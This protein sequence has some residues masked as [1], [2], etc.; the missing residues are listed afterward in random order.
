L[1]RKRLKFLGFIL[2]NGKCYPDPNKVDC[3]NNYPKPKRPLHIN[4]FLGLLGFYRRFIPNMSAIAL[5]LRKLTKKDAVWDWTPECQS[6][7]ETLKS[8]LTKV[9]SVHLPDLNSPFIISC[10]G[11]KSGLGAVLSQ[12][13][14]G[15][16]YPIY[17]ASKKLDEIQSRYSAPEFELLAVIWAIEKFEGYI[18]YTNFILETDHE[19]IKWLQRMKEPSGRQGRWFF[20]LQGYQFEVRH[21][22]GDSL[23]M[24]VPDALSR[25]YEVN[26]V[27][28]DSSFCRNL[29]IKEQLTDPRMIEV[30]DFLLGTCQTTD[31]VKLESLR[32]GS[33]RTFIMEDGMLMR[34]V[35]PK[36]KPW[37]DEGLYW[38]IWLPHNL[39]QKVLSLFHESVLAGHLG[40]RKTFH[41][42][43]EKFYWFAMRRDVVNFVK[44]CTK[45]QAIK[46]KSIPIAPGTSYVAQGPW[47][48]VF[49]DIMGPYPRTARQNTHLLVVVDGFSKYVEIFALSSPN[50]VKVT[51]R[52]WEVC[53]RW[54][55]FKTLVSDN[56]TQFTAAH[57]FDWC[58]ALD[59]TPF[60]ISAYHAQ[61]NMTE[62]YNAT[63]K[64]VIISFINTHKDW[65]K[66]LHEVC[67]AL[68]SAVNDST[69]FTP[70]YLSTGRELR[71]P[72]DNLLGITI[73]N[74][75]IAEL[76]HR[77][78]MIYNLARDNLVNSQE[79][80]IRYYNR[81]TKLREFLVGAKVMYRTHFLSD[82][83]KGFCAK[84]APR[85]EGPYV[86]LEKI[87]NSVYDLKNCETGQL[88][89]KV[90][91]NDLAS[92]I[93][94]LNRDP[95]GQTNLPSV[96]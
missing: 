2:E 49:T 39:V 42:V 43:E 25:M 37:E 71:T 18:E 55:T 16:R 1:C 75:D 20:K 31:K 59:I 36:G 64:N 51:D 44:S 35:G 69:K 46:V 67:F 21:R 11:S 93:T 68:R 54:G 5:P 96:T 80:N 33:D 88:V 92:F 90:H 4:K 85:W 34:Y 86:I 7:F 23:V 57:Y 89:N 58:K 63:I 50:S 77:M 32:I 24:R 30:R 66:H 38:R 14:E 56:G 19:A 45:C 76:G 60:H 87:S 72:F 78:I 53:C 9:S 65:D 73:P 26:Y 52:L 27:D 74:R 40:I 91:A 17:F 70:S 22:P 13:K 81:N 28:I 83:S 47:E 29:V 79:I 94:A 41:R 61:A 82:A 6:S 8:A 84:L 12:E 15:V 95:V 10:D 3:V 62:R 48:L